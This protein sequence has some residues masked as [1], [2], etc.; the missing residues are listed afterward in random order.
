M[1]KI[2]KMMQGKKRIIASSTLLQTKIA[3]FFHKYKI[4]NKSWE[5]R[6]GRECSEHSGDA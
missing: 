3:R 2:K 1:N 4:L 5:S 6:W